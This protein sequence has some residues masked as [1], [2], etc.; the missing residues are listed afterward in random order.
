MQTLTLPKENFT[1]DM[2]SGQQFNDPLRYLTASSIIGDKVHDENDA[3]MGDIKDIMMDITTGHIH[4][5]VVEMGGFLGIGAKY[6]AIPFEFLRID[7]AR[8]MYIFT[9]SKEMFAEAPGF[10]HWHWP[11]TNF[12]LIRDSSVR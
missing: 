11:D 3:P 8:K 6:F 7:A 1:N 4:Y 5:Y 10:N 12:H 9:G 2:N